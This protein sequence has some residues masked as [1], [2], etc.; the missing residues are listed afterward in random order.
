MLDAEADLGPQSADNIIHNTT[1]L[2]RNDM[3]GELCFE[4]NP[5]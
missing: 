4:I 5:F 3:M 1:P 2:T